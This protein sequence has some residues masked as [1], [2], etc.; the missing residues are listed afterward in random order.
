MPSDEPK[1]T[2]SQNDMNDFTM[3]VFKY[4]VTSYLLAMVKRLNKLMCCFKTV[5]TLPHVSSN[6]PFA[7]FKAISYL[8]LFTEM[9][10]PAKS[11]CFAHLPFPSFATRL[12]T[13]VHSEL[14]P[15]SDAS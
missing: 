13:I 5:T 11:N 7:H 8:R 3:T 2:R 12:V 4:S 15:Q 14:V 10:S 6:R 9:L 1:L